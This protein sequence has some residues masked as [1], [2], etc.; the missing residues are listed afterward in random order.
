MSKYTTYMPYVLYTENMTLRY[1]RKVCF[2]MALCVCVIALF[3]QEIGA[4]SDTYSAVSDVGVH[5]YT[6]V[7]RY[8]EGETFLQRNTLLD[9]VATKKAEDI[10]T[11]QYF[12]H[13]SPDGIY[14]QNV[15]EEV[16]YAYIAIAENLALG[17]F[18]SSKEMVDAWMESPGHRENILSGNFS[19]I[20]IAVLR[21]AYKERMVW[22]G[23]Q[24]FALPQHACPEP[25][26][27]IQEEIA[28]MDRVLALVREV[29]EERERAYRNSPHAKTYEIYARIVSVYNA[30]AK[31]Q[32]ET[33]RAYNKQVDAY[34]TCI[35][36]TLQ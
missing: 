26:K 27:T 9:V 29:L 14:V 20:G 32:R 16:G 23:V 31:R 8:R 15:A 35:R 5:V 24:V 33:V 25:E 30:Y 11:R 36:R 1:V 3:P 19:E 6:N 7:E 28:V 4:V 21:G 34:N 12:A 13:E 10:L 18:S 2:S 17:T 22:V